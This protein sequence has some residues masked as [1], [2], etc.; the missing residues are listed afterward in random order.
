ATD[1]AGSSMEVQDF[2]PEYQATVGAL[3]ELRRA[4]G[5]MRGDPVRAAEIIVRVAKRR[6]LPTHLV[7]G[8]G[9]VESALAYSRVQIDEAKTWGD[10][11][12]SADFDEAYPVAHPADP[13]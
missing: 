4:G 12:V 1:W 11:G 10:V 7:L 8:R 3:V 6:D 9:A 13:D 2:G 5:V